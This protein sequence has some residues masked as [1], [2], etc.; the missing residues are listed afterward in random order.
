MWLIEPPE[1]KFLDFL[2]SWCILVSRTFGWS[3]GSE[4]L[5]LQWTLF[6]DV[7]L[8]LK[9]SFRQIEAIR[10]TSYRE[11]VPKSWS[12][13][14]TSQR[15]RRKKYLWA[16][17]RFFPN[18]GCQDVVRCQCYKTFFSSPVSQEQNKLERL[19]FESF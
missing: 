16:S 14:T 18:V 7:N 17:C 1:K 13:V 9:Q 8:F 19:S 10:E 11:T 2:G 3:V 5:A 6:S 4:I 15:V 12:R